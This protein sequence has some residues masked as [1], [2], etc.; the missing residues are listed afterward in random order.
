MMY[1]RCD[2]LRSCES[3]W[4]AMFEASEFSKPQGTNQ[5]GVR[6]LHC[7]CLRGVYARAEGQKLEDCSACRLT[8]TIILALHGIDTH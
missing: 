2:I 7:R 6:G 4:T 3:V 1:G 8:M 5:P